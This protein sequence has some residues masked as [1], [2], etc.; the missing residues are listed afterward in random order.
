[1]MNQSG[2]ATAATTTRYITPTTLLNVAGSGGFHESSG[3]EP[4]PPLTLVQ[5]ATALNRAGF[6]RAESVRLAPCG[7]GDSEPPRYKVVCELDLFERTEVRVFWGALAGGARTPAEPLTMGLMVKDA[8]KAGGV[9]TILEAGRGVSFVQSSRDAS[10]DPAAVPE[11]ELIYVADPTNKNEPPPNIPSSLL[12]PLVIALLAVDKGGSPLVPIACHLTLCTLARVAEGW[13]V[14]VLAQHEQIGER[15][16]VVRDFFGRPE[17]GGGGAA[18]GKGEEGAA[19]SASR[20]GGDAAA[21]GEASNCVICLSDPRTTAVL[22]CRHLC[23]CAPC[24]QQLVF[25]SSR[26]PV[27]RGP[28]ASLLSMQG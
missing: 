28:A 6:V 13:C 1:M 25:H 19:A 9:R 3:W 5:E 8:A 2:S 20:S 26:C 15:S 21:A 16:F 27:C 4:V 18:R 10:L 24:A 23:L 12:Y 22:P 14:I 7:G 11:A 17:G